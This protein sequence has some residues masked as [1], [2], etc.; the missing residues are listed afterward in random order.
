M[1][2]L[3]SNNGPLPAA[4]YGAASAGAHIPMRV[5]AQGNAVLSVNA[6]QTVSA[7]SLDIRSLSA[8]LDIAA[9]TAAD[10]DIRPLSGARDSVLLPSNGFYV[11]SAS[12]AL[13][14]GGTVVLTVDTAPYASSAFLVRADAISLLTTAYLQLAP[15]DTAGFYTTDS[16]QSGL[17][18]GGVYLFAPSVPLRYMRI[19]ATGVGS[20]LTAWHVG[21]I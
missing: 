7:G 20:Q 5:D 18:L 8:L 4:I 12:A 1:N 15:A 3:P 11:T 6:T 13:I 10:F 14:L 16:S 9:I 21:Q 2:L 19:Y 17:L